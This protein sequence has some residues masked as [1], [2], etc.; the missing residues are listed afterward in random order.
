MIPDD[1][2]RAEPDLETA[3]LAGRLALVLGLGR[4]GGGLETT[5][6]LVA[7]GAQ[8]RVADSGSPEALAE[9]AQAVR[10]LGAEVVFGPQDP[11]LLEGTDLVVAS[12]AIPFEHPL[13][14]EAT[15]QGLPVTTETNFVLARVK[16]P[17][18]GI[19][20][21]K[22]KSTTTALLTAMLR[23]A[24]RRVHQGGNIGHPLVAELDRIAPGD[25]VVLELSSFQLWWTRR[26]ER[27]PHVTL[28]TNLFP[29][30]LDRHG[31]LA[32][33]ARAK[34]AALDYHTAADVAVLPADDDAVRS[35]GW[36]D[37]GEARRV[38]WG[39]GGDIVLDTDDV[40]GPFGRAS[41]EGL[42]LFGAHNRRNALA[43]AAAASAVLDH[44]VPAIEQGA[45]DT[46]PLPHRLQPV[47]EEGGVLFVDDSNSTHPQAA[48]AALRA[49]DRPIVLIAG[50][51]DKG[52]D[53]T[54]LLAAIRQ[55]TRAVVAIGT[56]GPELAAALPDHP[57]TVVTGAMSNAVD[58][59]RHHAR[60]GDVVL[61]SPA[62]SSLDQY[63][64]FAVRGE[65]FREAAAASPRAC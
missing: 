36:L 50:G 22:G 13:L 16:A 55:H 51:K 57:V 7:Q 19:T 63:A 53:R 26:I 49:F 39:S 44:P 54:A 48:I 21:T 28:V 46:R 6:F 25:L 15:R 27:S 24:G 61:L 41:L 35:A 29:E 11:A 14:L 34:R 31:T 30:H 65:A 62:F 38:L 64:S 17:V 40:V 4:Y 52:A 42:Q 9:P 37:A 32:H 3:S 59:A 10:D 23:A 2:S 33:Y 5:R 56:T 8:V 58:A 18:L 20:G 12:P 60:P 1:P 47:H 43:A 45:R